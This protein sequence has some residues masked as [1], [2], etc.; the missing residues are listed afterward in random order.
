MLMRDFV[1]T[2]RAI[3][4]AELTDGVDRPEGALV[5]LVDD[6]WGLVQQQN[7]AARKKKSES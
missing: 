4:H 3:D 1:D 2:K 6:V 7:A 5:D